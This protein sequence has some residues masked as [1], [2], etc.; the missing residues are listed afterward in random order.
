ML[1]ILRIQSEFI[2][3]MTLESSMLIRSVRQIDT[4][5]RE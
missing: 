1:G 4:L 5:N 3:Q 2:T